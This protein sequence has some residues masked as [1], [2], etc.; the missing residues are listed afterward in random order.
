MRPFGADPATS[1]GSTKIHPA[2]TS[3][4]DEVCATVARMFAYVGT[5]ALIAILAVHFWRQLPEI[6][7]IGL[8]PR[9]GWTAADRSQPA[10]ARG[11]RDPNEKSG[12]YP[13]PRHPE[14][15][16][17]QALRELGGNRPLAEP[18]TGDWITDADKLPLR[19]A[20]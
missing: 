15:G 10:V 1:P 20:L 8:A 16:R 4:A 7:M 5:L 14:D 6:A 12:T 13:L 18:A 9:P 17:K 2:L 3:F 19:G 11:A